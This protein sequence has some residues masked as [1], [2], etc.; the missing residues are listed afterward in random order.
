MN[1]KEIRNLEYD[2][3]FR[4]WGH[5][6]KDGSDPKTWVYGYL[7]AVRNNQPAPIGPVD[8][9]DEVYIIAP[10]FADW[11]MPRKYYQYT[12]DP[13]SIQRFV[14]YVNSDLYRPLFEGDLVSV[15]SSSDSQAK[16]DTQ[17]VVWDYNKMC[18]TVGGKPLSNLKIIKVRQP[19]EFIG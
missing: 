18:A 6:L 15:E 5:R 2:A 1:Q 17:K 10:G 16:T 7:L 4:G 11:N 12:V 19:E 9:F 3:M 13:N 14:G 8:D